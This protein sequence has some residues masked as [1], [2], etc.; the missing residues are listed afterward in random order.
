MT[1]FGQGS[2]DY[3]RWKLRVVGSCLIPQIPAILYLAS[4]WIFD[5]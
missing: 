1:I 3:F 5:A 2:E 4:L